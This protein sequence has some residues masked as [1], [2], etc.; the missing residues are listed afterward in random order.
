VDAI[1]YRFIDQYD[2]PCNVID[3]VAWLE[4]HSMNW[5]DIAA[6]AGINGNFGVGRELA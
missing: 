5:L 1:S 4:V 3:A 2:E 6:H